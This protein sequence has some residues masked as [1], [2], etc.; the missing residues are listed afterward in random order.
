MENNPAPN[1]S[2]VRVITSKES[3]RDLD[4]IHACMKSYP[5]TDPQLSTFHDINTIRSQIVILTDPERKTDY[6][7]YNS[8]H[9]RAREEVCFQTAGY[10]TGFDL[11]CH[12][13]TRRYVH[14]AYRNGV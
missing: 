3:K 5:S 13:V 7:V 14:S 6:L 9:E 1:E 10:I 11:P 2:F 12:G 8:E 4:K